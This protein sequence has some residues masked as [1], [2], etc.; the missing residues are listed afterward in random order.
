MTVSVTYLVEV[1]VAPF[2]EPVARSPSFGALLGRC[3]VRPFRRDQKR[4]FASAYDVA[5]I[6]ANVAQI[7]GTRAQSALGDGELPWRPEFGSLVH[8]VRYM[9][10]DDVLEDL[11]RSRV[12]DALEQWEP[13]VLIKDLAATRS[14][15]GGETQNVLTF[16]ITYDI[17][18]RARSGSVVASNVFQRFEL[19]A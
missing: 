5:L 8:L 18:S 19:A 12:I 15:A 4:D 16:G 11:L 9:N 17:L 13:R 2:S 3:V 7:L 6:R 1:P 14:S 10:N